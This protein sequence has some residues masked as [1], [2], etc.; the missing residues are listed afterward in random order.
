MKI[1][2]AQIKRL[3]LAKLNRE[4]KLSIFLMI[5]RNLR[6]YIFLAI[7][8]SVAAYFYYKSGHAEYNLIFI[9]VF[10]GV[11]MRDITWFR[12]TARFWPVSTVVT[13]WN[14]VDEL[15]KENERS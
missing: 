6:F 2:N 4:K 8:F 13:D 9:G 11:F 5:A 3:E 10:L 1:S 14:K 15:I 7:A 12:M